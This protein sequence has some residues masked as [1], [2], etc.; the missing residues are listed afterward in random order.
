VSP[1]R[2]RV[3]P[4]RLL[5]LLGQGGGAA[6]YRAEAPGGGVVALK[7]LPAPSVAHLPQIRR[8]ILALTR[9]RHPG[10]VRILDHGVEDGVPWYTMELIQGPALRS[11]GPPADHGWTP[12][13]L[14]ERLAPFPRLC[15]A[16][17]Y[18]HG[19]GLVHRDLKPE[20]ILLRAASG[21]RRAASSE[22]RAAGP[23]LAARSS[24][25][26]AFPVLVD[27]GVVSRYAGGLSRETLTDEGHAPGTLL[28]MAPEQLRGEP[29]DA[30]AD[31][32]S[33]GCI[34]YE[35]CCGTPPFSGSVW[36][37]WRAH[38]EQPALAPSARV[39][40]IPRRLD[41]L[42]LRLLAKEPRDRLGSSLSVASA[43]ERLGVVAEPWTDAPRPRPYLYRPRLVGRDAPL[44]SLAERLAAARQGAGAAVLIAGASGTGKTR[45]ALEASRPARAA[46]VRVLTGKG[47]PP[48]GLH[49]SG[50]GGK[51]LQAL[52]RPL[53]SLADR[54]RER[55]PA[56]T[57][58][59]LGTAGPILARYEP[60]LAQLAG[61]A[62]DAS[63]L[64]PAPAA[65]LGLFDALVE[66]FGTLARREPLLLVL[67][68]LQWADELSLGFVEHL[69]AGGRLERLPLMLVGTY[70]SEEASEAL[71]RLAHV[72][73]VV[74]L[75]LEP[76][77]EAEVGHLV[78]EMLSMPRAPL[79]LVRS[80]ARRAK[81]NPFFVA[82]YLRS[83]VAEGLLDR[84]PG[85]RWRISRRQQAAS[86]QEIEQR[87][88]LPR[89]LGELLRRRLEGI[90]LAG[91]ELLDA[92]AVVGHEAP[93][94]VVQRVLA[95]S[96][97]RLL[98][99][100]DEVGRASI[101]EALG[102]DLSASGP[103]SAAIL[104]FLHDESREVLYND[105]TP[106]RRRRLH[107]AAAEALEAL[108][109]DAPPADTALLAYHR[110]QAGDLQQARGL[111]ASA[112]RSAAARHALAEA[113]RL[114]R[115]SLRV[116]DL[117]AEKRPED[118]L[119]LAA[120]V[121]A[122]L[123]RSAEALAE[124]SAALTCA[125]ESCDRVAELEA[126]LIRIGLCRAAGL[127]PEA[128][129]DIRAATVLLQALP[130]PLLADRLQEGIGLLHLQEGRFDEAAAFLERASKQGAAQLHA[131]RARLRV[132]SR[133]GQVRRA[134]GRLAE[135]HALL[136]AAAEAAAQASERFE[137]AQLLGGLAL[138]LRDRGELDEAYRTNR[139]A[140]RI[141]RE[142]GLRAAGA[143]ALSERGSIL[144]LQGRHDEAQ[145]ELDK[146]LAVLRPLGDRAGEAVTLGRCARLAAGRS[147]LEARRLAEQALA[148]ARAVG[149][150]W[151][152]ARILL[153]LASLAR[154]NGAA[155]EALRLLDEAEPRLR[156]L[157]DRV[158]LAAAECERGHHELACG[159]GVAGR[160][161]CVRGLVEAEALRPASALCVALAGLEHA[162]AARSADGSSHAGAQ[163]LT[164]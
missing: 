137:E 140:L 46:G 8:E 142:L 129:D 112:G 163:G 3:G 130:D 103:L 132:L 141:L 105:L 24:Q 17:A 124:A 126:H 100:L 99:A 55:G 23:G 37:V 117:A 10:I 45:L 25:L 161:Q 147:P 164:P 35:M 104:R 71:Q 44:A 84:G 33:L 49:G 118:R 125:R 121:L 72:P 11:L 65:R 48:A 160:L 53:Q 109:P 64:L 96:G 4:Y 157:G 56:E 31:L 114:L 133:L 28:Y 52:L 7:T 138:V 102:P 88:G 94:A 127:G 21:E 74:R 98:E 143:A 86:A 83:A 75:E 95:L 106:E 139:R 120:E 134:Q 159:L 40:G 63:P 6:V 123:G 68:D 30:R 9:L 38:Q 50:P 110:E 43:L 97:A 153:E 14:R 22:Q 59:L 77:T 162:V 29:I 122:P 116:A 101:L 158:G 76:L 32:Y 57:R 12:R 51:P 152:E 155:A 113:E 115:A 91:R 34:L 5:G 2:S 79:R 90:S 70:R 54:C 85:G 150:A 135:A 80:L 58:R 119:F 92:A 67:D 13:A 26:A 78:E 27:F 144:H 107:R 62:A 18:L 66:A 36:D 39:P 47:L 16:L 156:R 60:A 136:E 149:D 69:A 154:R 151:L 146:A 19:E 42:V 145:A 82:E 131:S 20:N 89:S 108:P 93:A 1:L 61:A 128:W 81:G 87:L 41:E 111:Y 15:E 148:G 73:P